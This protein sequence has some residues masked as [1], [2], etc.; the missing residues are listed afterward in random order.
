MTGLLSLRRRPNPHTTQTASSVDGSGRVHRAQLG[1][2]TYERAVDGV[3]VHGVI[4]R[5]S[6]LPMEVKTTPTAREA[7]GLS[8]AAKNLRR[9]ASP[10]EQRAMLIAVPVSESARRRADAEENMCSRQ[11]ENRR[12]FGRS[13]DDA[14]ILHFAPCKEA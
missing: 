10:R 11:I 9:V 5:G 6:V 12:S 14:E 7:I 3:S 4:C 8:R 2:M 13:N 1:A